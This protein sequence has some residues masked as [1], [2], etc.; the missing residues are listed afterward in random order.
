M[1]TIDKNYFEDI[2]DA[3]MLDGIEG[4]NE[5]FRDAIKSLPNDKKRMT[6]L[7]LLDKDLNLFK[8]I[9][10][11]TDT[12]I[13]KMDH[14]KDII[15]MLREYVKVGEVEKKKFGEVM[16]PLDLVKEMLATLP[17]EVWS[18]PNL[19]WLDPANGTGPYPIMVIYKLMKG[20][21][22][23]EPNEELRYKH[24]IENMIYV[25]EIQP[26]NQFLY[27]CAIDPKD[28]Y[29]CNVYTGSFLDESFDKHMKEVWNIDKFDIIIGNP[30]YNTGTSGGNGARD[31]WDKFVVNSLDILKKDAYLVFVHPSK[32]R[33]PENSI[34]NTFKKYNLLY[35]EI[36]S[37]KDGI[38]IFNAATR[39]DFYCLQKSKYSGKTIVIDEQK[40][41]HEISLTNWDWLPNYN[42]DS[43]TKIL[44]KEDNCEILYSSSIYDFRK[45]WMS[46][47]I[48]ETNNLPCIYGMY[49]DGTF[50]LGYSSENRG[51]FGIKK[52]IL[53]IGRY[54]YPLIDING[55]YGMMNNAFAIKV[56]DEETST[57]IKT[58]IESEKF[59]DIVKAT[60]WGNFQTNYK[61]FKSFK[62]DF[63]KEFI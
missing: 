3:M 47:E 52:V 38:K 26:K 1:E 32:W 6:I 30:P 7:S 27:L 57:K 9:K 22:E 50:S 23:W 54:L 63:W 5:S 40:V 48:S 58:A 49:N 20:L 59:K 15:L 36:H 37:D 25:C 28:E 18:N 31:L 43:I 56:D 45:N 29:T 55:E 2:V 17:V 53:G 24:I 60:K 19:K 41:K 42:Y 61:M 51:H 39:Y 35:L 13:N 33:S 11:L 12:N 14:I 10:A 62:K 16:T 4:M 8:K 46:K 21:Q 44:S 34:F